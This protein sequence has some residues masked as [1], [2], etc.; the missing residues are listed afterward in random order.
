MV[1]RVLNARSKDELMAAQR[2]LDR[3]LLWNFLTIPLIAVEGSRVIYWDKLGRPAGG[4]R[5]PHQL[6]RGLVVR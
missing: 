1:V 3:I 5:V 2:A 4:C 6:P